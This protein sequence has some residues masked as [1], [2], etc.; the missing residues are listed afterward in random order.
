MQVEELAKIATSKSSTSKR[1][2][3]L[4]SSSSKVPGE[5]FGAE[6]MHA[7]ERGRLDLHQSGTLVRL[8]RRWI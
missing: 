5:E 7:A 1:S 6:I 4:S 3:R 2:T 8:L